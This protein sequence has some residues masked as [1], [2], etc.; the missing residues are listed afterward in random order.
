LD[1]WLIF[2]SQNNNQTSGMKENETGV[3]ALSV[4]FLLG[5]GDEV[6]AQPV[7]KKDST[8]CA[9]VSEAFCPSPSG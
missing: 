6:Y 4:P 8:L 7:K 1:F 9:Q 2:S 5:Y 3:H